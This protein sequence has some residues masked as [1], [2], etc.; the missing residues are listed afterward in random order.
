[1]NT[2]RNDLLDLLLNRVPFKVKTYSYRKTFFLD[3]LSLSL[4]LYLSCVCLCRCLCHLQMN[5]GVVLFSTMYDM[6]VAMLKSLECGC[7]S[8][9]SLQRDDDDEDGDE[10]DENHG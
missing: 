2:E 1:M 7:L 10:D 6:W 8:M 3:V 4:S 9:I 5:P